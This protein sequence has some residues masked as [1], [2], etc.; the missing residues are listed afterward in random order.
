MSLRDDKRTLREAVVAARDALAPAWRA[1]AS[2]AIATR[3]A[4]T[5]AFARARTVLLTLPYRSEWNA[6]LLAA[7]AL[8]DDKI[9]AVP[10][11]DASARMLRAFRIDHLERDVEAGYHGIPEPCA[12]CAEVAFGDID[13]VLVPGVA[14]DAA[15]RRLGYGGGYYDR[16]LPFLQHHVT[17]VAGA[18]DMQIVD[19]VPTAPHDIGV[20]CVVTEQRTLQR[21][22]ATE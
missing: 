16:L 14:F 1:Q 22:S 19:H 13:W 7:S 2:Q 9:V 3:I 8:V 15:G 21:A 5:D 4:H 17:R 11:V 18:F 6:T 10:R 12:A 20:D